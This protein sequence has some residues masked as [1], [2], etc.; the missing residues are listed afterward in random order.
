MGSE[1]I[2]HPL[3]LENGDVMIM[4]STDSISK[5]FFSVTLKLSFYPENLD[6]IKANKIVCDVTPFTLEVLLD[7]D[8]HNP[9]AKR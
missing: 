6:G 3:P 4:H 7:E 5:K 9:L 2:Y 8:A 1:C